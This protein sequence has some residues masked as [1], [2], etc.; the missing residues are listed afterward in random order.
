MKADKDLLYSV[1][2]YILFSTY[3][4]IEYEHQIR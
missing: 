1:F 2:V 4:D 3:K